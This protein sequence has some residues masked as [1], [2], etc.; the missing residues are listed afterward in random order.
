MENNEK[1][2]PILTSELRIALKDIM[3]EEIQKVPELMN[4]LAPKDRLN[5]TLKM[6]PYLFPKVDSVNLMEGESKDVLSD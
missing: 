1:K 4:Q 3:Q 6:M 5:V 2:K